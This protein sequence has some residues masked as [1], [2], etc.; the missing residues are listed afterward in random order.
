MHA[1]LNTGLAAEPMNSFEFDDGKLPSLPNAV[2]Y[3][4]KAINDDNVSLKK[5]SDLLST[6]PVLA[7]R[8]VRVSNSAFYRAISPAENV[9]AAVA[10]IGFKDTRNIALVLLRNSF[11][12]RHKIVTSM[13]N[14]LWMQSVR[15]AAVASALSKHYQLVDANRA[16]L[17]GLMYNVGALLLLTK[18][19]DKVEQINSTVVVEA[20][21]E[22]QSCQFGVK[23]LEHWEMDP[24]LLQV[25][26]NRDNWQRMHDEA[27]D[28]ADL[29]LVARCCI[30]GP[31]GSPPDLGY[32]ESL[33][34]YKRMHGFL[35]L[36]EPLSSVVDAAEE[37]IAKTLDMLG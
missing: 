33:P 14:D 32:C 13:I 21:L 20:I 10:R 37:S 24:E 8:L 1:E 22:K 36:S 26:A 29:I 27:P 19:D 9:P 12:A 2:V 23:L 6:D 31:D 28:L 34:S 35:N 25:V 17:G 5:L 4:E 16:L 18:I 3:L 30:P 7:A 15:I 11:K